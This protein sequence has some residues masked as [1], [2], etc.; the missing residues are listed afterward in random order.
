MT[1][2]IYFD[3]P[4]MWLIPLCAVIISVVCA[5]LEKVRILPWIS[6]TLHGAAIAAIVYLGGGLTDIFFMLTI[7]LIA[8][9]VC[10]SIK[11]KRRNKQ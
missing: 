9:S 1:D 8:S 11:A 5:S 4:L 10:I 6:A 7:S 3:I 2:L